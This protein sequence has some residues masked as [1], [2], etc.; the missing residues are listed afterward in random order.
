MGDQAEIRI[1][2]VGLGF[3]RQVHAPAFQSIPNCRV[4]A[5]AGRR[6]DQADAAAAQ[7]PGTRGFGSWREMLDVAEL[8]AVSIAVPPAT[9]PE[10]AIAA[11]ER[12]L[13]VFCEKP[14]AGDPAAA[15]AM[16]AAVRRYGVAHAVNFLFPEI[17]AWQAA[18][19]ATAAL[20]ARHP[21]RQAALTWRVETYAHR[22]DLHDGWKRSPIEGGGAL[23][24]FVSHSLYY[25]EWLFGPARAVLARLLPSAADDASVMAWLDFDSGLHV[26]LEVATD[27]PFGSGHRLEVYGGDGAVMLE[28]QASD[29]VRGFAM[30]AETRS[31]KP[32]ETVEPIP[33]NEDGRIW[34]TAQIAARFSE[35]VRSGACGSPD[36]VDGLRV[37]QI[38]A[39]CRESDRTR[40]WVEVPHAGN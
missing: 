17:P 20:A 22:H 11:A 14:A 28:N 33:G 9:Q 16:L 37:Q 10:I 12:G 30:R 1:G 27:C 32:S 5:L 38:L 19:Q 7:I 13:G 3:G 26:T 15:E 36:L 8:D 40:R 35:R 29:Y 4:V 25:L 31:G 34:A 23:N 18:K 2:V 24:T 6:R 21:L 39:A